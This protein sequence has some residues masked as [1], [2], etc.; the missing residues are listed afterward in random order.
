[1]RGMNAT[2]AQVPENTFPLMI[3]MPLRNIALL[4]PAV[5]LMASF[6]GLSQRNEKADR[7]RIVR[8]GN[9]VYAEAGSFPSDSSGKARIDV[10]VRVAYDFLVFKKSGKVH[11]D[12]TFVARL[13][14]SLSLE[15]RSGRFTENG[16]GSI[17][18]FAGNYDATNTRDRYVLGLRTFYVDPGMYMARLQLQDGNSTL[19]RRVSLPVKAVDFSSAESAI[20]GIIPLYTPG[21]ENPDQ[22]EVSGFSRS[23][24]FAAPT[25]AAIPASFS[26]EATWH[27]R[28]TKMDRDDD[29]EPL[30]EGP[31]VADLDLQ[32]IRVL[33]GYQ[34][35]GE[36]GLQ[37]NFPLIHNPKAKGKLYLFEL[38]F[39]SLDVGPYRIDIVAATEKGIDSTRQMTRVFWREMPWSLNDL[40]YSINILRYIMT[41]DEF[42]GLRSG[43]DEEKREKFKEFWKKRDPTPGTEHNEAMFEYYRRV[44]EAFFKFRTLFVG[45]GADTDRGKIYILFGPPEDVQR[46]FENDEMIQE[47]WS[48]PSL[49]KTFRFLDKNRDRNLILVHQ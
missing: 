19:E 48:Y 4:L 28:V 2:Q 17:S 15:D 36:S 34:P 14:Y 35:E 45:D 44:D 32:P 33:D 25:F 16:S 12:S 41:V 29:D 5:F 26:G 7:D 27:F 24:N 9:L 39:Q 43:T 21:E 8:Y 37:A 31:V 23:L 11:P 20:G 47:L 18:V 46:L 1:M 40:D 30:T 38:P 42:A 49:N 3:N 13:D 22:L 6:S 10:F